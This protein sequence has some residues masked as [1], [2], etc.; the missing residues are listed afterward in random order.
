MKKVL[1]AITAFLGLSLALVATGCGG[2]GGGGSDDG[3]D[4][5][6][7][8]P[9]GSGSSGG[10]G[11]TTSASNSGSGERGSTTTSEDFVLVQGGTV[12]G[13]IPGSEVFIDGRSVQLFVKWACDHEV[14]VEEYKK[15]MEFNPSGF[16]DSFYSGNPEKRPADQVS[17]YDA[18]MYCNKRSSLDG[19]TPCYAVNGNTDTSQWNYTPHAENRISGEITCNF[20]AN[21]YRLPTEAEW[22][23]LARGGN[24]SNIG[25]TIYSGSDKAEDVAWYWD[26]SHA[27]TKVVKQKSPNTIGLYDMSGN[28]ME[29]CWDLEVI[30]N[31]GFLRVVR[32]G[33]YSDAPT[34]CSVAYRDSHYPHFVFDK[35]GFRVV[36]SADSS[37]L[38]L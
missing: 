2:G 36:R 32:G 31:N 16:S 18:I 6:A 11:E 15:V 3:Y 12:T 30:A 13:K 33:C 21:G 20:N 10:S 27:T 34:C 37:L 14:T 1:F 24:T 9:S 25:Q 8:T 5:L 38:D 22:E 19:K 4:D 35:I 28:V 29:W 26:N 23:Y 7:S 17:W